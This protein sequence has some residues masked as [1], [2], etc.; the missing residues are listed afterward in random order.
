MTNTEFLEYLELTI[1]GEPSAFKKFLKKNIINRNS[2]FRYSSLITALERLAETSPK[3]CVDLSDILHTVVLKTKNRSLI[4]M[5][6]YFRIVSLVCFPEIDRLLRNLNKAFTYCKSSKDLNSAG[7]AICKKLISVFPS[8]IFSEDLQLTMIKQIID[9]CLKTNQIEEA[10]EAMIEASDIFSRRGAF[11]SAYRILNDADELAKS[12]NLNNLLVNVYYAIARACIREPDLGFAYDSY[13]KAFKLSKSLKIVITDNDRYNFALLLMRL[14]RT[15][16]ALKLF[17]KLSH[18]KNMAEPITFIAAY[19]AGIC[20]KHLGQWDDA[21]TIYRGLGIE[22]EELRRG[23]NQNFNV[24]GNDIITEF[25]IS[26]AGVLAHNGHIADAIYHLNLGVSGIEKSLWQTLRPHF[27]KGFRKGFESRLLNIINQL[28]SKVS[29]SDLLPVLISLKK[30]TQSDWISILKW[31]KQLNKIAEI[32]DDEI[33]KVRRLIKQLNEFGGSVIGYFNEKY[34]DPFDVLGQTNDYNKNRE[35]SELPWQDFAV[36]SDE[37]ITKYALSPVSDFDKNDELVEKLLQK[38]NDGQILLFS[39]LHEG[40]STI[41]TLTDNRIFQT[42]IDF[43]DLFP[44]MSSLTSYRLGSSSRAD[45]IPEYTATIKM[46]QEKLS[47][48]WNEIDFKIKKGIHIFNG[49]A[50]SF[51]PLSQSCLLNSEVLAAMDRGVFVLV[52]CPIMAAGKTIQTPFESAEVLINN[53]D[54]L[55]FFE[56]ETKAIVSLFSNVTVCEVDNDVV[57][58]N[59]IDTIGKA[60]IIHVVTHGRPLSIYKD[61]INA[62]ISQEVFSISSLKRLYSSTNRLYMLNSC[63]AAD[64]ANVSLLNTKPSNEIVGYITV[65]LQNQQ[66]MVIAPQWPLMDTLSYVFSVMFYRNLKHEPDIPKAFAKT[67]SKLSTAQYS[68]FQELLEIMFDKKLMVEKQ[69]MLSGSSQPFNSIYLYGSFNL[70][71]LI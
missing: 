21:E 49:I 67:I 64:S 11:P 43:T 44:Y 42:K 68:Y 47:P 54:K 70:Y 33:D 25:D 52:Q 34:D 40:Y 27:K 69:K 8:G 10:V 32:K 57:I 53:N 71:A 13:I 14:G 9:Y 30:N 35:F 56:E 37:L 16:A 20:L 66:S 23:L 17:N 5:S 63:N 18:P 24:Q 29:P 1:L 55:P 58:D 31:Q 65:L 19:H 46:V 12:Y 51:L 28:W 45:F 22:A 4:G 6:W 50:D 41:F 60:D 2:E 59:N 7:L 3:K 39:F 61:T 62:S 48:V 38:L 36:V 26:F 15:N